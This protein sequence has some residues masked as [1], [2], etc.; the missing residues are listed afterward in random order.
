MAHHDDNH[1]DDSGWGWVL[2]N[3]VALA[4]ITLPVS[5]ALTQVVQW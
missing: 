1:R 3:L 4:W 5:I 2:I